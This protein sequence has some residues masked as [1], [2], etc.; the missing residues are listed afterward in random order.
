MVSHAFIKKQAV[1]LAKAQGKSLI[2][3]TVADQRVWLLA[4]QPFS[5][6]SEVLTELKKAD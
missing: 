3:S 4:G 2:R 1:A 5:S 6:I